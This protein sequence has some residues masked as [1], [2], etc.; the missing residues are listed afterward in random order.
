MPTH[1]PTPC[2]PSGCARAGS[3][4]CTASSSPPPGPGWPRPPWRPPPTS[5]SRCTACA[6]CISHSLGARR[7]R[8]RGTGQLRSLRGN[9]PTLQPCCALH[10][11]RA[12]LLR[13][14]CQPATSRSLGWQAASQPT[15]QLAAAAGALP[16]RT[17]FKPSHIARAHQ[18]PPSPPRAPQDPVN[19]EPGQQLVVRWACCWGRGLPCM[20]AVSG[21]FALPGAL[22]PHLCML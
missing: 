6:A 14:A 5:S 13:Y 4:T 9:R 19:W 2:R 20:D 16:P 21:P 12:A 17:Q 8:C 22:P 18:Q 1:P 15:S 10:A 7:S 3:W 11:G